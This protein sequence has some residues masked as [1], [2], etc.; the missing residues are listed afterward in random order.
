MSEPVETVHPT[1]NTGCEPPAAKA[2][3][4][5]ESTPSCSTEGD[6]TDADGGS[7]SSV[8]S[9]SGEESEADYNIAW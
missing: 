8:I 1:Q 3:Q 5:H 2:E 4:R 7:D 6:E 9:E